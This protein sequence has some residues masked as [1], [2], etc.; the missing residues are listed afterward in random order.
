MTGQDD[1]KPRVCPICHG[2]DPDCDWEFLGDYD[3]LALELERERD[4]NAKLVAALTSI[5]SGGNLG[6]DCFELNEAKKE[7]AKQA[8]EEN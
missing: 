4:R 8:L 3:T 2:K 7:I 1:K 6:Q 5:L